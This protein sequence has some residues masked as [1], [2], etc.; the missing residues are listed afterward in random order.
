MADKPTQLLNRNAR[1]HPERVETPA[2]QRRW[3][4]MQQAADYI[5]VGRHTIRDWVAKGLIKGHRINA[6][7][8]RVDLNELDAAMEPFGGDAS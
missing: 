6:R 5:G 3:A 1:R 4:T 2:S 7:V 8:L